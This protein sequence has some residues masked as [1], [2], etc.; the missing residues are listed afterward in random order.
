MSK[1]AAISVRVEPAVKAELE[2]SARAD[3]RA[4]GA[5]VERILVLHHLMPRWTLR[6][7]QPIHRKGDGPR[8][9]LSVAEGS[10]TAVIAADDA[11]ALG[12]QLI[13]A[14]KIARGLPPGE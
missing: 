7:P 8:V 1:T 4:L 12:H 11:E 10:P 5:Y 3:G 6:D 9:A 2:K 13:Q 14:A